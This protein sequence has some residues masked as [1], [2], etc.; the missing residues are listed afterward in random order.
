MIIVLLILALAVL[1]VGVIMKGLFLVLTL[2][3]FTLSTWRYI[4]D[5][6]AKQNII[7]IFRR[8]TAAVEDV[9]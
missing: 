2:I 1:P 6:V 8:S 9:K 3:V 7:T 5:N 4:L